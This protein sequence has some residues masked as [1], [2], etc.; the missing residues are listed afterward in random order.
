MLCNIFE[1]DQILFRFYNEKR[2][3]E[4]SHTNDTNFNVSAVRIESE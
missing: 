4:T 3:E 2:L 1:I